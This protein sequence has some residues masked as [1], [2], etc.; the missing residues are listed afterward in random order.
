[1]FERG[2]FGVD[3]FAKVRSPQ[4]GIHLREFGLGCDALGTATR[5]D[6]AGE[7][8]LGRTVERVQIP[9][10][11]NRTPPVRRLDVRHARFVP[12]SGEWIPRLTNC[13]RFHPTKC[14]VS[15]TEVQDCRKRGLA[16]SR[17][18]S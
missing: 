3:V 13:D 15:G 10:R 7:G 16:A 5:G 8:N 4:K 6:G 11:I 17:Y 1:R 12:L 9:E 2:D 14:K 18:R